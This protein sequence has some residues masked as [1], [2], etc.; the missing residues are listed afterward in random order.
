MRCSVWK[1]RKVL[2]KGFWYIT[3]DERWNRLS[4]MVSFLFLFFAD[5]EFM[6]IDKGYIDRWG[7]WKCFRL[8][9]LPRGQLSVM[10]TSVFHSHKAQRLYFRD[11]LTYWNNSRHCDGFELRKFSLSVIINYRNEIKEKND[12]EILWNLCSVNPV[13]WSKLWI[14]WVLFLLPH[15]IKVDLVY[16]VELLVC[17]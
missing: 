3:K 5:S 11:S 15:D 9:P 4:E 2:D 7:R 8:F 1:K 12:C 14:A 10:M 16:L 6:I 13:W 17:L